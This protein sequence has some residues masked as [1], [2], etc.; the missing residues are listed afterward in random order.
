MLS[1]Q[2]TQSRAGNFT[3][4]ENHRLMAGWNA[5]KPDTNFPEFDA[6]YPIVKTM[7][8]NGDKLLVGDVS[9]KA[10]FKVSGATLNATKAAIQNET[11]PTGLITYAQEKAVETL[12]DS[13][14]SLG[15]STPHTRNGEEREIGCMELLSQK[16]GLDFIHTGD[17]QVH[18]CADGVG[19]TPDGIALDDL[20]MVLTGAEVKCKSPLVHAKN[21]LINNNQDLIESAFDHFT[22]IQTSM[23]V[24]DVNHWYFANYNPFAKTDELRFKFIIVE[25]DD[26]FIAVLKQRIEL[27]KKIQAEFLAELTKSVYPHNST[28]AA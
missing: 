26:K 23:L 10:G 13:D 1:E 2:L 11:P 15:F 8:D 19:C 21:L 4:S 14:P 6:L 9:N 12:F 20:D 7:M 17:D 25:R 28:K 27:A 3:A 5:P 24:T 16:T 22:Q 18:F